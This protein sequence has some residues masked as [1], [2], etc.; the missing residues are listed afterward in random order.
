MYAVTQ[1]NPGDAY[2]FGARIN[3]DNP[4]YLDIGLAG[5]AQGWVAV[6]FTETLSMV[7][8]TVVFIDSNKSIFHDH[9]LIPGRE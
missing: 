9:F 3:P 6:G 1:G 7:D 4:N 5:D 2:F 8:I